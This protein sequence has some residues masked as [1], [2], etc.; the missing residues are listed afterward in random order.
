[1]PSTPPCMVQC[2]SISQGREI[3]QARPEQR[4][5]R[6]IRRVPGAGEVSDGAEVPGRT[7]RI[8]ATATHE[9]GLIPVRRTE[10]RS[11]RTVRSGECRYCPHSLV[12]VPDRGVLPLWA[13]NVIY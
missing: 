2:F 10:R 8:Q 9:R 1:V 4:L 3:A 7:E 11:D 6:M 12:A 5:Q 13:C